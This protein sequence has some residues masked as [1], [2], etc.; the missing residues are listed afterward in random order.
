V[1]K[2]VKSPPPSKSTPTESSFHFNRRK[3]DQNTSL[4]IKNASY[5][6][7][8]HS[9][10]SLSSAEYWKEIAD[11]EAINMA[12]SFRRASSAISSGNTYGHK[13]AGFAVAGH[14]AEEGYLA[15]KKFLR[16]EL[17]SG[18]YILKSNNP[19]IRICYDEDCGSV[20]YEGCNDDSSSLA[21]ERNKMVKVDFHL[22]NMRQAI[23]ILDVIITYYEDKSVLKTSNKHK[24]SILKVVVGS[25]THSVGGKSRL[26]PGIMSYLS[27][28]GVSYT[29]EEGEITIEFR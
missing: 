14:I 18:L 10:S 11:R 22:L 16:A 7:P 26:K 2:G 24:Y 12:S 25:G 4:N 19:K 3:E 29:S 6:E 20:K 5:R 23:Q 15:R 8:D 9:P 28:R 1:K 21:S 27:K 13:S 17:M